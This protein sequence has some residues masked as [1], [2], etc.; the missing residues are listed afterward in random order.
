MADS[1]WIFS[2]TEADFEA[3]VLEVSRTTPVVVDFWATWCGPCQALGPVLEKA[4]GE[5]KGE[6]LLAKVDT[7][8]EQR[9][10]TYWNIE[11]LPTVVAF[12]GGKPVDDF[13][14]N[15][16]ESSLAQFLD[17]LMP[18]EAD[19]KASAG[20]GLERTDPAQAE[21]AYRD[22]LAKDPKLESATLGLARLFIEGDRDAEAAELLEQLGPGSDQGVE[23]ERLGALLW[24]RQTAR[25]LDPE[26]V[27]RQRVAANPK[28]A[29]SRYQLGVRL[30]VSGKGPEALE[31]LYS[32]G[33]KDAK[34][35]STRVREAMVKV[36]HVVGNRSPIADDYRSRLTTLLY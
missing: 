35:A 11:S 31:M 3:K 5:R 28:D 15:L 33:E 6:I 1:P 20:A 19:R 14:G 4:I 36:F 21:K 2:V 12:K 23:V 7:D 29:L 25:A 27:L 13:V 17:R 30:G 8:K 34:L 32:A 9:L 16:P 24:L 10:A 26:P 18:S 22:A